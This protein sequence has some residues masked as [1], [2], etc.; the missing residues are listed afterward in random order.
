MSDDDQFSLN[1]TE[2]WIP[3]ATAMLMTHENND[4]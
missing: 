2:N 3:V 4:R 1:N